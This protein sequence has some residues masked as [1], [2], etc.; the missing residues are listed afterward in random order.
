MLDL[1][2]KGQTHRSHAFAKYNEKN[3]NIR[4]LK[5]SIV[6]EDVKKFANTEKIIQ[7]RRKYVDA[8]GVVNEDVEFNNP[9]SAAQFVCGYSVSG[10][11]AWRINKHTNLARWKKANCRE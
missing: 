9:T 5:G 1:Y 11:G 10:P 4:V 8:D 7:L 3:G 6:S 2:I